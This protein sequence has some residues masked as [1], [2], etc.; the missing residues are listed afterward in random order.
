M[1]PSWLTI[2]VGALCSFT[3]LVGLVTGVIARAAWIERRVVDTDVV[4]TTPTR[5]G[6][7]YVL[8]IFSVLLGVAANVQLISNGNADDDRATCVV[9]Y[10]R[11]DGLARDARDTTG[12]TSTSSTLAFLLAIRD[13]TANPTG[14]P[15]EQ[16]ARFLDT[17]DAWI[18]A[19]QG[20]QSTRVENRYPA[21]DACADGHMSDDERAPE[22]SPAPATSTPSSTAPASPGTVAP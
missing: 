10:N 15:V 22:P 19:L 9:E 14:N 8:A 12:V 20:I 11:L 13:Q 6:L 16:L 3:F 21:P 17:I 4:P 18:S 5:R 1:I 7:L 2:P